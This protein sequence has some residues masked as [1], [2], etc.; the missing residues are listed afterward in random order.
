MSYITKL[1]KASQ[2]FI[3]NLAMTGK[4]RS[5]ETSLALARV[6]A[7]SMS[8]PSTPVESPVIYFKTTYQISIEEQLSNI[9]EI[10]VL[11]IQTILD[12]ALKFFQFKYFTVHSDSHVLALNC[13]TAIVDFF[14]ISK[15]FDQEALKAIQENC[16]FITNAVNN[17]NRV[18]DE[19]K[20]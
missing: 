19:I 8:V 4:S 13:E 1:S 12:Y 2:D 14:K 5:L 9:N 15:V 17:F 16:S 7:N 3:S 6:L 11:D 20:G 18:I 10:V